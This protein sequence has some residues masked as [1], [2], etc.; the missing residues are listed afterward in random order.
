M[1]SPVVTSNDHALHLQKS[2]SYS[3]KFVLLLPSVYVAPGCP[4]T[5][6][7]SLRDESAECEL[8]GDEI[9]GISD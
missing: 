9:E 3:F 6:R 4:L 1:N 7:T 8:S 5:Q 2:T